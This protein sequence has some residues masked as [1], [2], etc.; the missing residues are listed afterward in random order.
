ML[1]KV[2]DFIG[3]VEER[4]LVILCAF[5]LFIVL[6]QIANRNIM[7]LPMAWS[8]EIGRFSFTWIVFISAAY[9]IKKGVH[10]GVDAFTNLL[11]ARVRKTVKF[12]TLLCCFA[13]G[14]ILSISSGRLCALQMKNMQLSPVIGIPM[15]YIY[16]GMLVGA[17]LMLIHLL[18]QVLYY[19]QKEKPNNL[20]D[21]KQD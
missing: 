16:S 19:F 3:S 15:I 2:D 4:F 1:K 9:G 11:P 10:I 8:E 6:L 17:V 21:A 5:T 20:T 14:L 18:I 12:V 13:F 7:H